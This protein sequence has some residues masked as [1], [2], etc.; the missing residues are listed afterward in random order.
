MADYHI[1]GGKPL[2]GEIRIS[3]AKNGALPLLFG[4]VLASG[5]CTFYR[6]PDIGDIRLGEEILASMGAR[7]LRHDPH[8]VTVD[9]A[10]FSPEAPPGLLTGKMRASSYLMGACLGRFGFAPAPATG[11]CDFGDRPLNCHYGVFHALGASGDADLHAPPGGLRGGE[12]T[13]PQVSVGATVNGLLAA[14]C[15]S[16][17]TRLHGCAIESHVGE[18]IRF[19]RCLGAD[20]RGAGTP[21]L[22]IYGGKPLGHT[23]FVISPDEIEAGTYLLAGV[24]TGGDVTVT[25]I[26]PDFLTPLLNVLVR[27]GCLV[28][29]GQDRVRVARGEHFHG[30]VVETAPAPGFPTDL[31]PPLAAALCF[32]EGRSEIR[33]RVW[34]HRFRY[35]REL[36]K[37]GAHLICRE[38]TLSILPAEM[39]AGIVTAT[40]LRGGAAL[41]IAGL[42]A[43]GRTVLSERE[44]LERGY[45]DLPGKLRAL[46]GEIEAL[47]PPPPRFSPPPEESAEES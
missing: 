38:D 14:V 47:P 27:G 16:G 5:P 11:G 8:T 31:H 19:L 36:G 26:S 33:E 45:E 43:P 10:G 2:S 20:I 7:I 25:E 39:H 42:A 3:G 35:T 1:W 32:G 28:E 13:Y 6:M 41:V 22:T 24:A 34:R 18:L 12:Y 46:G 40:D 17:V 21:D 9:P 37:M 29:R 30:V 44:L 23:S 4:S 15:A